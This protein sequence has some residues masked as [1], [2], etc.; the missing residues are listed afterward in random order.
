MSFPM[1]SDAQRRIFQLA[2]GLNFNSSLTTLQQAAVLMSNAIR[3]W[4]GERNC[5]WRYRQPGKPVQNALA[6]N[7]N[8]RLRDQHINAVPVAHRSTPPHCSVAARL[9]RKRCSAPT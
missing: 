4:S 8:A 5:V 3:V 6:D 2:R 7:F 9:Q 1:S